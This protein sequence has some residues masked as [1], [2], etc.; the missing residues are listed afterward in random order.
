M[1][2]TFT[3]DFQG[4]EV[5]LWLAHVPPVECTPGKPT[6]YQASMLGWIYS[7]VKAHIRPCL[8]LLCALQRCLPGISMQGAAALFLFCQHPAVPGRSVSSSFPR[9]L[10]HHHLPPTSCGRTSPTSWGH[11][12]FTSLSQFSHDHTD[13]WALTSQKTS[14]V[15]K[16]SSHYL[17][18]TIAHFSPN[19]WFFLT[20]LPPLF[21]LL[22]HSYH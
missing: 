9:L 16:T 11:A 2:A 10:L 20:F 5:Q 21:S 18:S 7:R 1:T 15:K 17:S 12:C 4:W 8:V 13:F 19:R 6:G 3:H 14:S 22:L